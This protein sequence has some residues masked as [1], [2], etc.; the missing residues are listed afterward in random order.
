M[1]II[2]LLGEVKVPDD[3]SKRSSLFGLNEKPHVTK[4]LNEL[5]LDMLLLPYGYV[6][7]FIT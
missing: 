3:P 6:L 1:L 5:M 4:H 2:P 7:I